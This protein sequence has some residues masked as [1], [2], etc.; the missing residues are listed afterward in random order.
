MTTGNTSQD[1]KTIFLVD[2][3]SS[4]VNLYGRRLEQAGF[5]M[6]S[7]SGA[8]E[9][10][11]ALPDLSADLIIL[12]LMLPKPG[13]LELLKKIRSGQ[14]HKDT[15]ILGLANE[16]SRDEASASRVSGADNSPAAAL[17][18]AALGAEVPEKFNQTF[19]EQGSTEARAIKEHCFRYVEVA[20]AGEGK[21][22]LH[23][24]YQKLRFLSAWGGL[25]GCGKIAQL[26]EAIAAMLFDRVF[27]SNHGMTPSS[28]QTL[29]QAVDCL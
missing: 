26:T 1:A 29:V 24:V 12:D 8:T 25:V 19:I 7:A 16:G 27:G 21:A 2:D 6:A 14:R 11:E 4:T 3:D 22:L 23:E 5:R 28:V 18:E 15:P 20:N 9:A 13:G 17:A 10:S